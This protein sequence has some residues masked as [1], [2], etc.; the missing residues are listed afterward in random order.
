MATANVR[1]GGQLNV[2]RKRKRLM[3]L[4]RGECQ[5]EW[6]EMAPKGWPG[7]RPCRAFQGRV[8]TLA[9]LLGVMGNLW[10][11]LSSRET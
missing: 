7:A 11:V 5:G 2:Q 4:D 9:F 6:P 10:K 8:N 3:G 1:V